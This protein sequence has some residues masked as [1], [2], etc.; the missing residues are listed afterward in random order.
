MAY[1][2]LCDLCN[3][4]IFICVPKLEI[5]AAVLAHLC[6]PVMDVI[7]FQT[8]HVSRSATALGDQLTCFV[9][10]MCFRTRR[11]NSYN[12][13]VAPRLFTTRGGGDSHSILQTAFE[14]RKSLPCEFPL[15]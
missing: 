7:Y 5:T 4:D 3:I 6:I 1:L 9:L 15:S 8:K 2:G 12:S 13:F 10:F 14:S 11:S